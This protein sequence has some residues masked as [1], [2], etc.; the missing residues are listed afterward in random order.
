M[1]L[2]EKSRGRGFWLRDWQKSVGKAAGVP[3]SGFLV[4]HRYKLL[5]TSDI[6]E[7]QPLSRLFSIT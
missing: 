6:N 2:A 4:S 1:G 3:D 7:I 5:K